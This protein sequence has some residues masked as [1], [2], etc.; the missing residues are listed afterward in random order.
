MKKVKQTYSSFC[1]YG[2]KTTTVSNVKKNRTPVA[3][4]KKRQSPDKVFL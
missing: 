2:M 1:A 4:V 3:P